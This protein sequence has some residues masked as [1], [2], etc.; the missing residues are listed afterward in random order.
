MRC[1][2]THI[3]KEDFLPAFVAAYDAAI[4]SDN[5]KGA[6]KALA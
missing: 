4:N 2:F 1:L 3:E 6:L 5:I